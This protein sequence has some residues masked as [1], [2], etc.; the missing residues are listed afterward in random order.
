MKYK[1]RSHA[2]RKYKPALLATVATMTLGVSTL[3]STAP[4]FA[5]ENKANVQQAPTASVTNEPVF[6]RETNGAITV[7]KDNLFNI[8]T[9]KA[10]GSLGG[11]TL[12]QAWADSKVEG[13]NFN[14]TFRTLTMGS[15][16]LIPYG[17]VVISPLIG[18]LWPEDTKDAQNRLENLMKDIAKQTHVQIQNYDSETLG[19]KLDTLYKDLKEFEEKMNPDGRKLAKAPSVGDEAASLRSKAEFIHNNFKGL[20][21]E[22]QKPSYKAAEFP[23]FMVAATAHLNFLHY[24]ELH[25]KDPKINYNDAGLKSTFLDPQKQAR[26]DYLDYAT[27]F[28]KKDVDNVDQFVQKSIP[29]YLYKISNSDQWGA[30][31]LKSAMELTIKGTSEQLENTLN[32]S[33]NNIAF[34]QILGIQSEWAMNQNGRTLY[35]DLKGQMQTGWKEISTSFATK[36]DREPSIYPL[37][38][39]SLKKLLSYSWYYFSP[40]KTDNFEKGEMYSST[41]KTIDGK[42]YRFNQAGKCLNPDGKPTNDWVQFENRWYYFSPAD[43]TKN[44]DGVTFKKGDMV[45]GSIYINNKL[46][47]FNY[48]GECKNPNS[49][50]TVISDGTYKIV[51]S[52]ANKVVDF[53]YDGEEHPV[54]W[55]YHNGENQQWEFKYDAEKNAYQIINKGDKRVLAYNTSGASDTALVTRNDRKPEHYWTLEDVGDGTV[56]LVN[57]ANKNKVLDVYGEKTA[58]GSRLFVQDKLS[59]SAAQKFKLVKID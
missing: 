16:A 29:E 58:G 51:Y 37:S 23:I 49:T 50:D 2:K 57:Y 55:D 30:S 33:I 13:G 56:L 46:Y 34:K 7:L 3:G 11:A 27:S 5:A 45:T 12:K 59:N 44:T 41:T 10:I 31:I 22:S 15:A 52:K 9:L 32:N 25:G 36:Y 1:N 26:K 42:T 14:N 18:L 54:I 21:S 19:R 39:E 43:G 28:A 48:K 4:A 35:Y 6:K 20:I 40:E 8:E 17:G 38:H 53:G 47:Q 24:M